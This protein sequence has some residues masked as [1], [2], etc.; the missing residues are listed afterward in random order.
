MSQDTE[1]PLII[2]QYEMKGHPRRTEHWNLIALASPSRVHVF[3]L[4]GNVNT[5]FYTAEF[6]VRANLSSVPTYRGGCHVGQI[7]VHALQSIKILLAQIQ[8]VKFEPS[9]DC[10]VWV[11]EGVKLLKEHGFVFPQVIESYVRRELAEDMERWN[12]VEDT[13]DERLLGC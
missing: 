13:V 3:E 10:Q 2:A 12:L 1:I 5:Y 8:I 9:W 7:P 4:R 11:M 6:N